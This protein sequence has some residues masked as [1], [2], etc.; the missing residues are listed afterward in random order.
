MGYTLFIG[1]ECAC[2]DQDADKLKRW[3]IKKKLEGTL[4]VSSICIQARISRKMFYYWWN[5]YQSLGWEGLKEKPKGRPCG[6]LLEESIKDKVIK[7]RKRYE[8]GPNKITG[9]LEHRGISVY[10]HKV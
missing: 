9:Y 3:I 4:P 2:L 5:R 6:P 7:I 8:W 10:H 1:R